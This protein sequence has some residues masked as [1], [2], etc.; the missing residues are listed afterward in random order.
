MADAVNDAQSALSMLTMLFGSKADEQYVVLFQLDPARS[1]SFTDLAQAAS[2]A[3]GKPN[4][5]VHVGLSGRPYAGGDR[6]QAAEI[7]ALGGLWADI[8]I[9]G[10]GHKKPGLPPDRNA[11]N[12]L[13][14]AL[15]LDPGLVIHSGGGL[16]CWWPFPEVWT[17]ADDAERR[18]ARILVRAWFITLRERAKQLGFAVDMVS[19]IA[20]VLR[21]SG[22]IN[23]KNAPVPVRILEQSGTTISEDDVLGVL[24]DGAWEQAERDIDG[25][26]AAGDQTSYGEL[27]LDAK[28][29][30]P[31]EKLE[32]LR[33]LE[34]RADQAWR[35]KRTKRTE[36]WSPSEW[37]QSLA[38]YA[39][40]AG[41]SRQEI[42]NLL[43]AARRKHGEELKLRQDYFRWTIDKATAGQEEAEA[44]REAVAVAEEIAQND[45][46]EPP[47]AERSDVLAAISKSL[48]IE[49]TRV[50]R[51]PSEPPVFGIE[52]PHGSGSLGLIKIIASNQAFRNRVGEITNRFP[53][54]LKNEVW[55]P[56]AQGLLQV[57]ETVELGVETTLAGKAET[58]V[59]LYLGNSSIQQSAEMS[60]KA[61]EVLP[62][63]QEPFTDDHGRTWIFL[64]GF[65]TWLAE[66][67]HEVMT[68]TEIGTMLRAWGATV[69]TQHFKVNGKRTTRSVWC[70]PHAANQGGG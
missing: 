10:P 22:T 59:S 51:S 44:I 56:I 39:A 49:I 48:G 1:T 25:K 5:Y 4:V 11:A 40:Q 63:R 3:A 60:D 21:V 29:E 57:A 28:T 8:D 33:D 23:A 70:L 14:L 12:R 55:D 32:L 62:I 46:G 37:D 15:G 36:M 67:Q 68:R 65:K 34:P 35:R 30:P 18:R 43:I 69:D 53:K 41:W 45:P 54:R 6:P 7:D 66:H 52:T 13:L 31:W 42:A 24:L 38:T 50:T 27:V 26:K 17:F 9:A 16:Q 19:D 64:S 58:L 47:E 20:R 2:Y 61:R